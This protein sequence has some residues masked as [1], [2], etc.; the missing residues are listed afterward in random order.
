MKQVLIIDAPPVFQEFLTDKL[1]AEKVHSEIAQ[2]RRDAFIKL[3]SILPE[4]VVVDVDQSFADLTEFLV[5]KQNDPN[6]KNI[7]III[8]GPVIEHEKLTQLIQYGVIKYFTKPVKFDIFFETI[9]RILH[10]PFTVDQTPCVLDLHLNNNIIFIEIAEG[11]N[12]EKISLLKYKISEMIDENHL[13]APKIIVM[14]TNLS[15]S[16]VD[17][18]NLELLF[19]SVIA[20]RRIQ[21]KNIKVLS[22]DSIVKELIAGHP[23][24]EGIEV[25]KN[26]SNVINSLVETTTA[27]STSDIITNKILSADRNVQSGSVEMRFLADKGTSVTDEA[28]GNML[29]IAVVDD[30]AVIRQLLQSALFS[31]GADCALFSAGAD[32]LNTLST[33]KYN[34]VI[35][36]IFMQ[37]VSGFEILRTLKGIPKAPPVIVYSQATQQSVVFQALSL[38][39]KTFMIKPQKPEAISKKVLEILNDKH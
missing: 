38:G 2:G 21:K 8:S 32:F 7:P 26:L 10:E 34:L 11:L 30:D 3:I 28:T 5:K 36:D 1:S 27:T 13:D 24:Y 17:A 19:N 6:A 39:A 33:T 25:V 37:G 20:D 35:L 9:G 16:F 12:R 23:A 15:L 31:I 29:K 22:L 14:L 18:T 4:L